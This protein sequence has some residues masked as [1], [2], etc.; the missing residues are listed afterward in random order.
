MTSVA[1]PSL[2]LRDLEPGS[3][4]RFISRRLGFSEYVY[5][6]I[7]PAPGDRVTVESA[8]GVLVQMGKASLT[9]DAWKPTTR[10]MAVEC[11]A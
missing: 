8:S 10:V 7:G 6:V 9:R 5:R 11:P 3:C 4:F 1:L 2:Q